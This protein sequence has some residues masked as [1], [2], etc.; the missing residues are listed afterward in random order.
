MAKVEE[1]A[2]HVHALRHLVEHPLVYVRVDGHH[3]VRGRQLR[4]EERRGPA[5]A[6]VYDDVII[7]EV[8]VL[9]LHQGTSVDES[10]L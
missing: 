5:S 4:R 10:S 9:V 1:T 2:R 3:V 6:V 7:A 8:V